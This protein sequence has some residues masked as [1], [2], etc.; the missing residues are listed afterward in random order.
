MTDRPLEPTADRSTGDRPTATAAVD[1][2]PD[3]AD[4]DRPT[5]VDRPTA[6]PTGDRPTG[7]PTDRTD[8][9]V[10]EPEPLALKWGLTGALW[11]ESTVGSV[12]AGTGQLGFAAWAGITGPAAYGVPIILDVFDVIL[13]LIGY[14][15]GRRRRSPWPWWAGAAIVGGFS[16]YTNVVHAG[17]RAGLIYGAASAVSLI[18]WGVKL[19]VDLQHYLVRIGHIPPGRPKF[20][21][22][23]LVAPRVAVRAWAVTVRRRITSGDLA[24]ECAET[25]M[26]VYQDTRAALRRAGKSR[27][28]ARRLAKR[29]ALQQLFAMTHGRAFVV[30][31]A[32]EVQTV[33]IAMRSTDDRA[34]P[35]TDRPTDAPTDRP[36][37]AGQSATDRPTGVDVDRSPT[38][39][40]TADRPTVAPTDR[41]ALAASTGRRSAGRADRAAAALAENIALLRKQYPGGLPADYTYG[42]VR[43]DT[44]WSFERT[45]PAVDGYRAGLGDAD[46]A[47]QEHQLAATR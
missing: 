33:A 47:D 17:H 10:D 24:V 34:E 23:L 19:W 30:P 3:T 5:D 8:R 13:L 11:I 43:G 7:D 6:L 26:V 25:W 38:V 14:R 37:L 28:A 36:A 39:A 46:S 42:Q 2:R 9:P 40:P 44:G 31:A 12:M 21:K 4:T 27:T 1:R 16:V 32:A 18:S 22:L 29:T 15:Q 35:V 45:K 41:P 20:G